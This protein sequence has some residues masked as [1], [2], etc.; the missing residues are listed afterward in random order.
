VSLLLKAELMQRVGSKAVER[1]RTGEVLRCWGL[2]PGV[3]V[4][5]Y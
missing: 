2:W 5:S 3:D 4:V 1:D